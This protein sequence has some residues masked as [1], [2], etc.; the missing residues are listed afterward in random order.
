LQPRIG[1]LKEDTQI[2]ILKRELEKKDFIRRGTGENEAPRI[3]RGSFLEGLGMQTKRLERNEM[4][5][6]LG[7]YEAIVVLPGGTNRRGISV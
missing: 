7:G 3:A 2:G 4:K 1:A 5:G 6:T